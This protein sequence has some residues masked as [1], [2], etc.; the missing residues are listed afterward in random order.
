M[1]HEVGALF[2]CDAVQAAGKIAIDVQS[3]GVDLLTVTAHKLH[4]PKGVGALYVRDGV[5][6][7]PLI[8]GGRQE[9]GRR[10]GTE[11]SAAIVGFGVAAELAAEALPDQMPRIAG[12]RDRLELE[13]LRLV[14]GSIP[15]GSKSN[16]LPNTLNIAF[17]DAEAD[18]ILLLLERA[19]IAAS[20]G[21]ACTAGSME[22][23]HVLRAM[24]VPFSH[25]R[26]AVRFSFSR[27]NTEDD[28]DRVLNVLPQI[29][30]ELQ[31]RSTLLEAACD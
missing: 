26:G 17:E 29:A 3:A 22:P 19:S 8:R 20:S 25:L 24:R 31:A 30:D 1:A 23:S 9:R 11:N 7:A 18:S 6:F 16:R 4:G 10:A 14:P 5:R 2:H 27:E 15:I 12:L 13:T 28:V 21:S